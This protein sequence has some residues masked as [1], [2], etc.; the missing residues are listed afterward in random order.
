MDTP[1]TNDTKASSVDS[2]P[3]DLT[4]DQNSDSIEIPE[5]SRVVSITIMQGKITTKKYKTPNGE[6]IY[7]N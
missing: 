7:V 2:D 5:G 4:T 3:S 6:F 1:I